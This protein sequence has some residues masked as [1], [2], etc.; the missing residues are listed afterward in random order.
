MYKIKQIPEDFI[1]EEIPNINLS[2]GGDYSYFFIEK[3]NWNTQDVIRELARRL[4]VKEN[5]FNIAGIK[6]KNAIT[7][8][9][10]SAYKMPQ[11]VIA[12]IKIKDVKINFIGRGNDRIKLGQIIKN[13]FTITVRNLDS[14]EHNKIDF[15]ENYFDEQRFGGTNQL[16]G[17]ALVKKDFPEA[18]S[19]LGLNVEKNDY[20]GAIRNNVN[21]KMLVFYVNAY[22]SLLFNKAVSGYIK[23]KSA[24]FLDVK[25]ENTNFTFT[26]SA[27]ENIKVPII[28]FLSV[29][30]NKEIKKIYT[31]I[32]AKEGIKKEDFLFPMM[33]ELSSEG[34]ERDLIVKVNVSITFEN[35]EINKN[36]LKAILSFSLDKGAYATIV[37]KK[38]FCN[39]Q[40]IANDSQKA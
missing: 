18:C 7:R 19:L 1:V 11:Q 13:N 36:K 9:V 39:N 15:I 21:R 37:I 34:N 26:N 29:I 8:Q 10:V 17:S 4:H 14:K 24:D 33:P 27:I 22:Q 30:R 16:I 32:L 38:M 20:I 5:I 40:P 6:D 31:H 28:G 2:K 3:K 12:K 35:D 23:L 25:S